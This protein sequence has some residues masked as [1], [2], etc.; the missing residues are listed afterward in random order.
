MQ[1]SHKV[2]RLFNHF[3]EALTPEGLSLVQRLFAEATW[4]TGRTIGEPQGDV[5]LIRA[6]TRPL[7]DSDEELIR[8]WLD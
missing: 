3:G 2:E 7:T 6:E 5:L 8:G 1:V 4:K